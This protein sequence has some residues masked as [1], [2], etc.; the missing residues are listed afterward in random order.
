MYSNNSK[1]FDLQSKNNWDQEYFLVSKKWLKKWKEHVNYGYFIK[2]TD[3]D[4]AQ[5]LNELQPVNSNQTKLFH[6]NIL[7]KY[8]PLNHPFNV[9]I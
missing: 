6:E 7:I 4:L 8:Y 3:L 1:D 5:F 2:G 9:F